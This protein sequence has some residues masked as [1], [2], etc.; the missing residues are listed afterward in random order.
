V[1]IFKTK[2]LSRFAWREGIADASLFEAIERAERGMIDAD[3]GGGLI[4]QRVARPGQGRSGGFRTMVAYRSRT[5]AVFL[6][7]FAKNERENITP[8]E[9][10][11]AREIAATWLDVDDNR[12]VRAIVEGELQE[13]THDEE[14]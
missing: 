9:L 5:R 1:R 10:L 2:W 13:I 14:A 3:L 12:L 6:Y 4:K 8:D 7:G 11:T